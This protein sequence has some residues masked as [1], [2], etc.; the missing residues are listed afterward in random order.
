MSKTEKHIEPQ[1]HKKVS[2]SSTIERTVIALLIGFFIFIS[3]FNLG[4]A[5]LENWDEAWYGDNIKHI[6]IT[7]DPIIL[8]FNKDV[9][10]EKPPLYM[11]VS[12][13]FAWAFGLSEFSVRIASA[14]CGIAIVAIV[15]IHTYRKFGFVP[16]LFAFIILGLNDLFIWRTRTGNLDTITALLILL[17]FFVT[18][19]TSK[20]RYALFGFLMGLLYLAKLS[21]IALP[22]LIFGLYEVFFYW[23]N[24]REIPKQIPQYLILALSF[25]A[26][27]SI[28]LIPGYL[29]IGPEFLKSHVLDS[30]KGAV[31]TAMRFLNLD[32]IKFAYYSLQRRFFFVVALGIALVFIGIKKKWNFA[33]FLFATL[34]I[35][36]L[37]FIERKN[38][39]YL[40]PSIPFWALAGAYGVHKVMNWLKWVPLFKLWTAGVVLVAAFL[41]YRT[42]TINLVPMF[43]TY[44]S[45]REA[46]TAKAVEQISDQD[47]I[48]VR[49]DHLYPTTI[50][51]S[52]RKIL[53]SPSGSMG[54]G[55]TLFIGRDGAANLIKSKKIFYVIG[56]KDEVQNY[57]KEYNLTGYKLITP[58]DN[59]VIAQ[60]PK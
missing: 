18:I 23:R 34:L 59:E 1:E 58:I 22:I 60:F 11:W 52:N 50:Y 27:T 7:K 48:V 30:D 49:L 2:I 55:N 39:W 14:L 51:Y 21:I 47:D 26:T 35:V 54:K 36:Q 25:I 13:P 9:F 8:I 5:P 28:W 12:T 20:Y 4:K 31:E 10:W 43:N 19:S 29:K 45:T 41:G 3:L 40:V 33:V 37:S 17:A 16:A 24:W 6:L 32:Y 15:M 53:S 38:N 44:S 57:L 56:T 42:Y 46:T